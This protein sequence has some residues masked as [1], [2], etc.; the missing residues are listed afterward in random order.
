M[1]NEICDFDYPQ[2]TQ[3]ATLAAKQVKKAIITQANALP[4]RP[5]A[6]QHKKN[7]IYVYHVKIVQKFFGSFTR[8]LIYCLP[9]KK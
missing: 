1:L 4:W 5:V 9:M 2:S 8:L 6:V 3:Y 7:E